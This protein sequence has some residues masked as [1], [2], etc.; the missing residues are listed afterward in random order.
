MVKTIVLLLRVQ[1][2][3]ILYIA[4][5]LVKGCLENNCPVKNVMENDKY[6]RQYAKFTACATFMVFETKL[7]WQY[8]I[9]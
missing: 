9:W 4:V 3:G 2:C 8:T 6:M 5:L 7:F 1:S